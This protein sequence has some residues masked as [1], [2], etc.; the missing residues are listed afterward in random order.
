[1]GQRFRC[2]RCRDCGLPPRTYLESKNFCLF[3]S[4]GPV[5]AYGAVL[6]ANCPHY[7]EYLPSYI[8]AYILCLAI[9]CHKTKRRWHEVLGS[10]CSRRIQ[11]GVGQPSGDGSTWDGSARCDWRVR[12][13]CIQSTGSPH[14]T[15]HPSPAANQAATLSLGG[16]WPKAVPTAPTHNGPN[17]VPPHAVVLIM[18]VLA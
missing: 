17:V 3:I 10:T 12:V 18:D 4:A 16:G 15:T 7:P 2:K 13:I 11:H 6:S 1:M 14:T 5:A 9:V 8:A